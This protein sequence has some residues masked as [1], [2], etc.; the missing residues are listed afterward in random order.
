MKTVSM[1]HHEV[2]PVKATNEAVN[3]LP[4]EIEKTEGRDN[5]KRGTIRREE[6]LKSS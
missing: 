5:Q 4:S 3:V 6:H 2:K 1:E